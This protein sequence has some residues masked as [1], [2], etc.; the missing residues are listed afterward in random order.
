MANTVINS[1]TSE[2]NQI[3]AHYAPFSQPKLPPG[4]IFAAKAPRFTV[5]A[6]KSGKV[7]FQGADGEKEAAKWQGTATALSP[8]RSAKKPVTRNL[9]AGFSD[10]NVLGSDEVGTGDFFG[11]I[12]VCASYV[13]RDQMPLL[14][15]L[16]VKDSKAMKDPEICA[17]A[18]EIIPIIP[19]SV[20]IC[21]NPKYNEV[22]RRGMN[23]GQIKAL[24]HNRALG[25]VLKRIA[26]ERPQAILIDQF[27]EKNTYYRYLAHETEIVRED[28]FFATKAE[29]LHLSV[30]ASSII[31]RYK[32]VE[33]FSAMEREL[34]RPLTKGAGAKV[35]QTAAQ[36]IRAFGPEKL[37]QY[38]KQHF[39]NTEKAMKLAQK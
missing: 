24:L 30:A 34:G 10:W 26:P 9:P 1:T 15:A 4:A 28:V 33:A 29:G 20:L 5:T 36:I 11:P 14:K 7:M 6:Y 12:T 16:G 13:T 38:T 21:P 17:I 2:I 31:A 32:F 3:K 27:A 23:Q 39:A 8:S 25:N 37:A 22:I 18:K 35:D 19:H